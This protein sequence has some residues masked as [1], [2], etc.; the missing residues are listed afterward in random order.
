MIGRI[1]FVALHLL[2]VVGLTFACADGAS[3][4]SWRRALLI[5]PALASLAPLPFAV[6]ADVKRNAKTARTLLLSVMLS[7]P[8]S[9]ILLLL[10]LVFRRLGN[11]GW[12]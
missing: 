8:V 9:V 11:A 4:S 5:L 3:G 12:H 10:L 6:L 7:L 1:V 2:L